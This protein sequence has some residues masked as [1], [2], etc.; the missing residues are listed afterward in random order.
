MKQIPCRLYFS[1]FD[2]LDNSPLLLS[3]QI[4]NNKQ[5]RKK[6]E[7]NTIKMAPRLLRRLVGGAIVGFI[8]SATYIQYQYIKFE[9]ASGEAMEHWVHPT[10]KTTHS[11][12]LGGYPLTYYIEGGLKEQVPPVSPLVEHVTTPVDVCV[13]GGGYAG[14]HTTLSLAEKGKSVV[15][16]EARRVG[17]RASGRNGGDAIIGFHTET[18]ELAGIVGEKNAKEIYSHSVMGYNRLKSIIQSYDIKCN[19]KEEGALTVSFSRRLKEAKQDVSAALKEERDYCVA[20]KEKFGEEL[21]VWDKATMEKK[22]LFS[23]RFAYGIYNPKNLTLNPMELALGLA[24]ACR[25]KGAVIRE[26]S[27]VTGCSKLPQP[28]GADPLWLVTT[29]TGSVIARH[30]VLATNGAPPSL[31]AKLSLT[32]APLVT[33]MMITKP[34]DKTVLDRVLSANFAIFDERFAL[35]Y[36]RRVEGNRILFGSLAKGVPMQKKWAEHQL[37]KDLT[38]TFPS[39]KDLVEVDLSWQGRLEAKLPVFPLIGRDSS[40]MW[41]SLGYS[42]H[43]LVPTC[44]G[45]ELL[46]SAIVSLDAKKDGTKG[47]PDERYKL[48]GQVTYGPQ[49]L[50][51]FLP[52]A[53]PPIGGPWGLIASGI[54]CKWVEVKDYIDNKY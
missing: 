28:V 43:G 36:F 14:L 37:V 11:V 31:S 19:A 42:G 25:Q 49:S 40:G 1:T 13:I 46:A 34:I 38:S 24:R 48:W 54:Y 51:S 20:V 52:P 18:E 32:T 4:V 41:Y 22:G 47:Q 12:S 8:G 10:R 21:E 27:P 26:A 7:K 53:F 33:A 44:A 50:P 35:A 3:P 29:E 6:I 15:V 17:C 16:L 30:V 23:E 5:R 45:G 2:V 9:D 39:L